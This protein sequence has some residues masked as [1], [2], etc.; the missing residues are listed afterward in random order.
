MRLGA[1]ASLH[2]H[3]V[4]KRLT[5]NLW[6]FSFIGQ[7]GANN[8]FAYGFKELSGTI[9]RVVFGWSGSDTFT[10]ANG[11]AYLSAGDYA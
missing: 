10:G 5:G 6:G 11:A 2:G 4:M 1:G 3:I 7:D 8:V 9:D